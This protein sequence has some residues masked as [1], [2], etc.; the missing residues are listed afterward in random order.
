M[1]ERHPLSKVWGDMGELEFDRLC[2]DIEKNGILQDI[3]LYEGKILDGWHRYQACLKLYGEEH[4]EKSLGHTAQ[5][6]ETMGAVCVD[7]TTYVISLNAKR[8]HLAPRE[9]VEKILACEKLRKDK[10]ETALT[11][12]QIAEKAGTSVR[13]VQRVRNEPKDNDEEKPARVNMDKVKL[14]QAD[15]ALVTSAQKIE[16]LKERVAFF[17]TEFSDT[18][19]LSKFEQVKAER[20]A[21]QVANHEWAMKYKDLKKRHDAL[22]RLHGQCATAEG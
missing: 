18:P 19:E 16:E 14:D 7:P 5:D 11:N 1:Y 2:Q 15:Q 3:V 21:L 10:G 8:R 22:V 9:V 20:D 4:A 13:T 17:E 6:F 12:K